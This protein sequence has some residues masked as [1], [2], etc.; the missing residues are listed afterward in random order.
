MIFQS[1]FYSLIT[2]TNGGAVKRETFRIYMCLVFM[3]ES[4]LLLREISN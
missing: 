2:G 4:G 3:Q 1:V